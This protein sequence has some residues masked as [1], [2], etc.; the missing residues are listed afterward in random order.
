MISDINPYSEN[1]WPI[2]PRRLSAD[3][4]NFS[5]DEIFLSY[6]LV[7][8]HKYPENTSFKNFLALLGTERLTLSKKIYSVIPQHHLD[9]EN[10][11]QTHLIIYNTFSPLPRLRYTVA[12]ITVLTQF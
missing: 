2:E 7:C 9:V 1:V 11:A 12:Q 6:I 4:I 10:W 5:G 3:K 8:P